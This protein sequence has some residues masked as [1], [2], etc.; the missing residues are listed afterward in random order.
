MPSPSCQI[1]R[2]FGISGNMV[3]PQR[4]SLADHNV[5]M[6]S[7][8]NRNKDFVDLLQCVATPK[9]DHHLH[10]SKSF[11]YA[12][13]EDMDVGLEDIPSD[14]LAEFMSSTSLRDE[15]GG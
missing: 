14:L 5:D 6:C 15:W 2:D 13:D 7:F 8:L 9:G 3:T 10:T 11:V 12:V 1:E 4:T